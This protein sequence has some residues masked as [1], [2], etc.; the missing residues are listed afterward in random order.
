[1][2]AFN[3]FIQ[4]LKENINLADL[5]GSYVPLKSMDVIIWLPALFMD[6]RGPLPL[7]FHRI[8]DFITASAVMRAAM[9]LRS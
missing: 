3:E 9:P 2:A 7:P 4:Q 1:M 6:P 5:I 8:R